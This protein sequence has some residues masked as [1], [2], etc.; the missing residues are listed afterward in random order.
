M[1]TYEGSG[2][3][4]PRLLDLRTSW[5]GV[6]IFTPLLLFT[7]SHRWMEPPY[8]L[9]R[10]MCGPQS[11]FERR[12]GEKILDPTGLEILPLHPSGSQ[13]LYRLSYHGPSPVQITHLL[14]M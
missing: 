7:P 12:G 1:K 9:N 4:D 14:T 10:R 3:M 6:V 2:C 11:R 5:S 13:S 8:P